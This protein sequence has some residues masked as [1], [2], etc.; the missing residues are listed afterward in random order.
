MAICDLSVHIA[1]S[2]LEDENSG[3]GIIFHLW[4]RNGHDPSILGSSRLGE[5]V[6]TLA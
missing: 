4:F 6:I 2:N 5:R 3:A 1:P